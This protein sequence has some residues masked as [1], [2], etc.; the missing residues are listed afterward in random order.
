MTGHAGGATRAATAVSAI[1]GRR[2][3]RRA[4][5]ASRRS[6]RGTSDRTR[7]RAPCP[8]SSCAR[9]SAYMRDRPS[10]AASSPGASGARSGRAVSAPRTIARKAAE[11]LGREAELLDHHVEGA[12]LAAMAP[13]DALDVE[14]RRARN[15]RP[16]ASTSDGATNRNT[17]ARIDEAADQPGQAMRSIF[18]RSRV[19]QTRAALRRRAAAAW[20]AAPG[21][22]RRRA[23]A[24]KP[25]SRHSA[26]EP[27]CRSQAATPWLSFWPFWQTT[28]ADRPANSLRPARRLGDGAPERA[29]ISRGSAAKSSSRAD[30]DDGRASGRADE[31]RKLVDGDGVDRRHGASSD[32]SGTRCFG[33]SPRGEIAF[34]MRPIND[35]GVTAVQSRVLS[36]FEFGA[37]DRTAPVP[38]CRWVIGGR[39]PAAGGGHSRWTGRLRSARRTATSPSGPPAARTWTICGSCWRPCRTRWRRS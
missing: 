8:A 5:C 27:A 20:R 31:A 30:I 33:M 21:A 29:G 16:T 32:V 38:S 12:E 25:P 14:G 18:G 24:S 17:A 6:R 26:G 11:R 3:S 19:T 15:D 7:R 28:I 1:S 13:E 23:Q 9:S 4:S 34:P 22:G 36:R 35:R 37:L 39:L 2:L 10:E